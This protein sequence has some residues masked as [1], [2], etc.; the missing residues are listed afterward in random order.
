MDP[1]QLTIVIIS[2]ALAT[3]IIVL[4]VQVW[5]ILKEVRISLQKMNKM[6][7][8]G[9]KV[10]GAVSEGVVNMSGFMNGLRTGITAITSILKKKVGE[11]E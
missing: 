7:D 5:F 10:T 2:F 6:L 3:L 11:D 9:G 4:G 1:T 8:D